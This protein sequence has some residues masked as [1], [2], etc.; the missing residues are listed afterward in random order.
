[1]SRGRAGDA[2][3]RIVDSEV[4]MITA[5][6]RRLVFEPLGED[7]WRLCDADIDEASAERLIAYVER[8]AT[9]GYEAIWMGPGLRSS[10]HASREDIRRTAMA[11]RSERATSTRSKPNPIPHLTPARSAS[12]PGKRIHSRP[13]RGESSLA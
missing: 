3:E 1:L 10:R 5:D 6:Q 13:S 9:G 11:Q 12:S 4:L 7:A 2:G 8:V